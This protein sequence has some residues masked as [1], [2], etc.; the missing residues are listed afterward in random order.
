MVLF[1]VVLKS[2][3]HVC[4]RYTASFLPVCCEIIGKGAADLYVNVTCSIIRHR[5]ILAPHGCMDWFLAICGCA[6]NLITLIAFPH[7]AMAL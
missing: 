5:S 1:Q 7:F 6:I 3:V 2:K 4:C